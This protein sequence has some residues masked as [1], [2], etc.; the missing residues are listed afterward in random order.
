MEIKVY[1]V[2]RNLP[3]Q[4]RSTQP[5]IKLAFIEAKGVRAN[6]SDDAGTGMCPAN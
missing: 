2:Y 5:T 1:L 4:L 3:F 6:S